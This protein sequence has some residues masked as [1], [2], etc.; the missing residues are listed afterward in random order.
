MLTNI[1][2]MFFA[3]LSVTVM[4]S[5]A[6]TGLASTAQENF[7]WYCAQCHDLDGGGDG[8]N[9]VDELPVGPMAL[10]S[11]KEM[12]KFTDDQI[13]Q[14]ITQGGPVNNLESLMPTWGNTLTEKEI[15]E[16]VRYVRSLCK[17]AD[18]PKQS[19]DSKD[20]GGK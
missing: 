18:C 4:V 9:S 16:L 17:E 15:K 20:S 11:A 14:T 12:I 3:G 8:I 13:V 6:Q 2:T 10:N 5:T 1:K 19:R 7:E